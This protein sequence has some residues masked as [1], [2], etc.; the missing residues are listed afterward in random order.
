MNIHFPLFV[1]LSAAMTTA[2]IFCIQGITTTI[3]YETALKPKGTSC[4][5]NEAQGISYYLANS[6][7]CCTSTATAKTQGAQSDAC[8]PC[9]ALCTGV[10]P[11]LL[12]WAFDTA[13]S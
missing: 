7:G 5:V 8:C 11:P 6:A 1:A 10:F 9:G 13:G 12:N 2:Q 3:A 4:P